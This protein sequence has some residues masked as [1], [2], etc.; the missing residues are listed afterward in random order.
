MH[1]PKTAGVSVGEF[2]K[3]KFPNNERSPIPWDNVDNSVNQLQLKENS[4][5][6]VAGHMEA[7]HLKVIESNYGDHDRYQYK[8]MTVIRDPIKR[9]VSEYYYSCSEAHPPHEEFIKKFPTL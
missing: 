5:F 4:R 2:L 1:L 6:L 8:V 7:K 9:V 3:D